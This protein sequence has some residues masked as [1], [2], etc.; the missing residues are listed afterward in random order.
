[1]LYFLYQISKLKGLQMIKSC[2][3][4]LLLLNSA[5]FLFLGCSSQQVPE[6]QGGFTH[7]GIYFGKNFTPRYQQG[8]VDGCTTSKGKYTKSHQLFNSDIDYNNGW[9]LGRK[10]C[11]KLLKLDEN[12][13]LVL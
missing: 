3:V 8:I 6:S 5:L 11:K 12:G 10:R 2:R 1:M 13:D 9:F 4:S 7:S